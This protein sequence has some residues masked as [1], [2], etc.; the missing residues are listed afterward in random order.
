MTPRTLV[1][2]A[3]ARWSAVAILAA[4]TLVLSAPALGRGSYPPARSGRRRREPGEQRPPGRRRVRARYMEALGSFQRLRVQA[5][6]FENAIADGEKR[7]ATCAHRRAT[8]AA[9]AYR[10][11]GSNLPSLLTVGDL[12]DLMRS[13]KLLATANVKDSDA[14]SL[15]LVAAG[16]PAPEA[17][18]PPQARR[19]AGR[20]D[21]RAAALEQAGRCTARICAEQ[22]PGRPRPSRRPDG[23][24]HGSASPAP[25]RPPAPRRRG[26]ARDRTS[27]RRAAVAVAVA[28][29]S[30]PRLRPPPREPGQLRRHQP[31][32]PVVRGVPVRRVDLEHHRAA[33][34]PPRPRR[35]AAVERVAGRP[36]R[37]G[38]EPLPVAGF[39][40]PGVG[41]AEPP[42]PS[43][44]GEQ[45]CAHYG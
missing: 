36:G 44:E 8:R 28:Q 33:R 14:L 39:R 7:A 15:L 41:A 35:R 45:Q 12:P 43:R 27:R 21:R 3:R 31:G 29:R 34:R 17:R 37:N 11:A 40:D 16:G 38:L 42:P 4:C 10:G 26:A 20:G 9:R 13:D 32:R 2:F 24:H 6:G 1:P 19:P 23:G 22:P 18:G 30:V 5:T 25:P